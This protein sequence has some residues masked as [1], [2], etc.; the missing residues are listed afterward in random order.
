MRLYLYACFQGER[1]R[2]HHVF[3]QLFVSFI[4]ARMISSNF[5][6]S[7]LSTAEWILLQVNCVH[8]FHQVYIEMK[9]VNKP[10]PGNIPS[11]HA[12]TRWAQLPPRLTSFLLSRQDAKLK[13][14][15]KS[16]WQ[17]HEHNNFCVWHNLHHRPWKITECAKVNIADVVL[18]SVVC[19]HLAWCKHKNNNEGGFLPRVCVLGLLIIL[20]VSNSFVLLHAPFAAAL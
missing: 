8:V 14:A 11:L 7:L 4:S 18:P 6:S 5:K 10:Q 17:T 19:V 1:V 15:D 3:P 13:Q 16:S 9:I 20:A 12:E 2:R